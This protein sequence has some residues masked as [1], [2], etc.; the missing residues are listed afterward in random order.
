MEPDKIVD[1]IIK[2][3]LHGQWDALNRP[4]DLDITKCTRAHCSCDDIDTDDVDVALAISDYLKSHN[5]DPSLYFA[6]EDD[7]EPP[8]EFDEF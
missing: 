1:L 3:Y 7:I 2:A 8:Y 4:P 6:D 5:I